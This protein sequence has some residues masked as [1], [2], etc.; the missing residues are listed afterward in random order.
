M[1]KSNFTYILKTLVS[2]FIISYLADK[3]VF[4]T[5]NGVSDKVYTGRGVGKLNQYLKIKDDLDFV[6]FGSSRANHHINTNLI[7]E[8]SF[9]M[10]VNGRKL[11]FSSILIKL[12]PKQKK[13]TILLQIDPSNAFSE[14][15]FG[16]DVDALLVQYNRNEIIAKEIDKL[17]QNNI[18]QN[19]YWSLS[20]NGTIIKLLKNYLSPNYN[21]KN[22]SGYDPIYPTK[23]QQQIFKLKV[24]QKKT[25]NCLDE[26]IMNDIYNNLL[27]D[28][29]LFCNNNNKSLL[30]YTS[31]IF[32]DDCKNDNIEFNKIMKTKG[33]KYFDLSDFFKDDNSLKYW[34]DNTH[35]SHIGANIFT[36]SIK[37]II[38][39]EKKNL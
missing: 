36:D 22:Y 9:N 12:L 26:Y 21:Y 1:S 30:I 2:F 33:L 14:N 27:D 38:N 15:Y 17:N 10:G 39:I 35:L 4:F 34:K 5:I 16:R 29:K 23:K 24:E 6:V 25:M 37:Q 3:I 28:L 7:S 18:L 20:Y 13:Q 8:N 32:D 11:A 31:P 19:F